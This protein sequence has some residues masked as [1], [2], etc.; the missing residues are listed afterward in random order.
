MKVVVGW[1]SFL[2]FSGIKR[3]TYLVKQ[4]AS[5]EVI[6]FNSRLRVCFETLTAACPSWVFGIAH[7]F[8]HHPEEPGKYYIFYRSSDSIKI[9]EISEDEYSAPTLDPCTYFPKAP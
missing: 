2:S 1:V 5:R 4:N 3:H 6:R 7:V 8:N 9:K